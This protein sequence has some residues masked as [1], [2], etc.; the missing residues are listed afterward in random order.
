MRKVLDDAIGITNR[1]LKKR[2]QSQDSKDALNKALYTQIRK[3][4]KQIEQYQKEE[5]YKEK[6]ENERA[7]NESLKKKLDEANLQNG[8]LNF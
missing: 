1:K 4:Q 2:I 8:L 5:S 3:M 6:Y 7:K